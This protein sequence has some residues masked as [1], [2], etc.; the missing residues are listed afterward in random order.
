VQKYITLS[1]I[2]KKD[3]YFCFTRYASTSDALNIVDR[4]ADVFWF[5]NALWRNV[6]IKFFA[7][8]FRVE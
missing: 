4:E 5:R 3:D 7:F 8:R 2:G 6:E 1:F